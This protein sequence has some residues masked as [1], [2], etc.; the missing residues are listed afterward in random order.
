MQTRR[1]WHSM[2]SWQTPKLGSAAGTGVC[3][4]T[5]QGPSDRLP[6]WWSAS[7]SSFLSSSKKPLALILKTSSFKTEFWNLK[8]LNY[9]ASECL[10]TVNQTWK[11]LQM[12]N[13]ENTELWQINTY[14]LENRDYG[15]RQGDWSCLE[16]HEGTQT[17]VQIPSCF[18]VESVG[19]L[20]S[21]VWLCILKGHY[22][23]ALT[24]RCGG[25]CQPERAFTVFP[26]SLHTGTQCPSI[27]I[28]WEKPPERRWASLKAVQN[29]NFIEMNGNRIWNYVSNLTNFTHQYHVG[30]GICTKALIGF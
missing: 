14:K 29:V 4:H 24:S 8:Q 16:L 13:T 12:M 1:L 20:G 9:L 28:K 18:L 30:L 19:H 3:C 6:E 17:N 15:K 27:L 5:L 21:G 23:N 11:G 10:Q 26:C 25:V 22:A 2:R 7:P